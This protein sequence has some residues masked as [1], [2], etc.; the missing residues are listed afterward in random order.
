MIA[1]DQSPQPI[2]EYFLKRNSTKS[3]T[4]YITVMVVVVVIFSLLPIIRVNL[5]I[6]GSGI[7][8]TVTYY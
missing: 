8:K 6:Q 3:Q 7:V 5:S 2:L 1:I 4:I